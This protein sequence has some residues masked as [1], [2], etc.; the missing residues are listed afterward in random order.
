MF[1]IVPPNEKHVEATRTARITILQFLVDRVVGISKQ[2]KC[3]II[4]RGFCFVLLCVGS[5]Y[6]KL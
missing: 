2:E 1:R 3:R 5:Y 4:C 6:S